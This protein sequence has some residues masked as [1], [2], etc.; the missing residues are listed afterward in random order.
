MQKGSTSCPSLPFRKLCLRHEIDD[1][2]LATKPSWKRHATETVGSTTWLRREHHWKYTIK[3]FRY[4]IASKTRDFSRPPT[5]WMRHLRRGQN[6]GI[7]LPPTPDKVF[8]YHCNTKEAGSWS[9]AVSAH[10]PST[11]ESQNGW[12]IFCYDGST[13]WFFRLQSH[14][15]LSPTEA[16]QHVAIPLLL[17]DVLPIMRLLDKLMERKCWAIGKTPNVY[18]KVGED[19]LGS[20]EPTCLPSFE[21]HIKHKNACY[22]HFQ[23]HVC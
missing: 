10:N 6:V 1:I 9:Q 5:Y 4:C 12:I 22:H 13:I 19:N 15:F 23:K 18:C 7:F 16:G 21:S 8:K 3:K 17:R 2:L 11:T 14:I 20:L